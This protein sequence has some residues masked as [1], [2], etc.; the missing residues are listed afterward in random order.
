MVLLVSAVSAQPSTST[1]QGTAASQLSVTNVVLD[2]AILMPH[3]E[4][5][6][7]IE[8]TNTGT[9]SV[10]LSVAYLFPDGVTALNDGAYLSLG[11]LGG[12][13]KMNFTFTIT[14]DVKDG[15]YYPLFSL[16][17]REPGSDS[18]RFPIPIKV[19]SS[20]LQLS[21]TSAP[22][23]FSPGRTDAISLSVGN[24]RENTL[25][26]IVI[27]PEG[28]GF[29]FAQKSYFVGDLAP[30]RALTV[31]FNVTPTIATDLTFTAQYRNGMNDHATIVILP[32]S[33][34]T[35]KTRADPVIN[36]IQLSLSGSVYTLTGDV[37]NAGLTDAR[38]V[39]VT[40]DRPARAVD[41]NPLSPLGS[42]APDDLSSF[43]ITFTAPNLTE[44]PLVITYK[45]LD[46]NEFQK[47]IPVSLDSAG[48]VGVGTTGGSS[49]LPILPIFI[50]LVVV[51]AV[52][53]AWNW[54]LFRRKSR[55]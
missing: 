36:N 4:G 1:L 34:G 25:K 3:D 8:V 41:P 12:G 18:L 40:V 55:K 35:D 51:I 13:N 23:T 21:V 53:I 11:T 28:E 47:N 38:G 45:D 54:G 16:G 14:A 5:L 6:V 29:T 30:G 33:F 10:P 37:T 46:G 52:V 39:V 27:V 49:S 43:E 26:G 24:P 50:V 20:E 48:L 19:E 15:V 9:E 22:N 32:V 2:P 42:L 7:T 17:F 44:V 31:M